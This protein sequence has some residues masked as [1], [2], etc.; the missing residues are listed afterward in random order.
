M[1]YSTSLPRG[2]LRLKGFVRLDSN[3]ERLRLVQGVGKRWTICDADSNVEQEGA[4][5]C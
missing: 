5:S 4:R 3:P 2:V 1:K